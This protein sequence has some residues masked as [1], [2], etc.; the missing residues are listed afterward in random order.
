MADGPEFCILRMRVFLLHFPRSHKIALLS[1]F[2][3]LRFIPCPL[4]ESRAL[5]QNQG[6][7]LS[8]SALILG[9]RQMI[10]GL[11]WFYFLIS[12]KWWDCVLF[13][14]TLSYSGLHTIIRNRDTPRDEFVFYSARLMRLLVEFALSF[15]PHETIEIE[16]P[17]GINYI[18]SRV[19]HKSTVCGWVFKRTYRA[20]SAHDC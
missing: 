6:D 18:G 5:K 3:T 19:E 4:Y 20:V 11:K 8:L 1:S 14:L 15:L 9:K 7:K 16:T 2:S 12:Y 17:Q 13:R 10:L